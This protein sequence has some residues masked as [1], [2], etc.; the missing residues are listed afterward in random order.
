MWRF[1]AAKAVGSSHL[2]R[3]QPCQDHFTCSVEVKGWF[4]AAV[5]DG[6]GSAA[7]AELGA[8]AAS[9]EAVRFLVDAIATGESD[10]EGMIRGAMMSARERVAEVSEALGVPPRELASTL[11][12]VALGPD[13]GGAGQIGDGV[14]AIR[15]DDEW[16]WVFW[17]Q[18]GQYANQTNFLIEED[19]ERHIEIGR[20]LSDVSEVCIVTDGLEALSL[21]YATRTAHSRF[22]DGF[23][24]P[25][26][27]ACDSGEIEDLSQKLA[28]FLESDRL[29]ERADDDLTLVVAS[30][31]AS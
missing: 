13:G 22:F 31:V 6:A 1:A 27:K 24:A 7:R 17:P 8:E 3:E 25:L 11:L 10:H 29:R 18:K 4:I 28:T 20:L 23:A 9:Q 12:V 19:S 30:R 15:A 26:R 16:M 14:I 2:K 5:A 21:H